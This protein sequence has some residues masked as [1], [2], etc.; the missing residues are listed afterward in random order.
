MDWLITGGA[1]NFGLSIA[2][3]AAVIYLNDRHTSPLWWA[4]LFWL[5]HVAFF[6]GIPLVAR[7]EG[8][9]SSPSKLVSLWGFAVF[10][11][12]TLTVLG[13]GFVDLYLNRNGSNSEK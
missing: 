6:I 4:V 7:I 10:S 5:I 12:A 8:T 9:Y 1:I 11:H 3:I 13:I 2:A